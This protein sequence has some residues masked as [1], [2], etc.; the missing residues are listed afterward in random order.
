[1]MK[2]IYLA[3]GCFWGVEKYLSLIPGVSKTEAGYANGNTKNPSYED[4]RYGNSGHA[5]TVL[6][7]YDEEK[8]TLSDIL[9]LFFDIIDPVSVNKQGDDVGIQYRTGIYYINE[10]D[11]RT[12]AEAIET[13]KNQITGK[14]AV[15]VKPLENYYPA[16]DYHQRY[17]EK[18][19]EGYCHIGSDNFCRFLN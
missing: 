5:E 13:L 1:M 6:V 11:R 7:E 14:I 8:V 19:P 3:G 10:A 9:R 12:A 2:K 4:V 16:E 15:E 18:N 17:L